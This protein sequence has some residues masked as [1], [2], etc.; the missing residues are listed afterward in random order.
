M[1][2]SARQHKEMWA[3]IHV[4]VGVLPVHLLCEVVSD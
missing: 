4:C 2:N 1:T 3:A